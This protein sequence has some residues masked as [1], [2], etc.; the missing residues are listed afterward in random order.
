MKKAIGF[1][2]FA[3]VFFC[4]TNAQTYYAFGVHESHLGL[5]NDANK[6]VFDDSK[7]TQTG[8]KLVYGYEDSWGINFQIEGVPK[9]YFLFGMGLGYRPL[10]KLNTRFQPMLY[11]IIGVGGSEDGRTKSETEADPKAFYYFSPE[12]SLDYFIKGRTA[13]GLYVN[14]PTVF[15][16]ENSKVVSEYYTGQL[17]TSFQIGLIFKFFRL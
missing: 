2:L 13:I 3:I 6:I 11:G 15:N 4:N 8:F 1:I 17:K 14:C 16:T 7:L 9:S 12:L 10:H 5:V